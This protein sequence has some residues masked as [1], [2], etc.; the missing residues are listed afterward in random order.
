MHQ[1]KSFLFDLNGTMIDDMEYHIKAWYRILN[2][3][4]AGISME[5]TKEECYGKNHEL[6]DRVFPGRFS[7]E[8]KNKMS[9]EKERQY[10]EEF[11][12]HLQLLAGLPEVL[13]HYHSKGI[14]MAIGSAAIMYNIDFVLDGLGIRHYFQAIVSAD[15]VGNSKPDP[16]TYLKCAGLLHISPSDCL[17]FEDAPKGV[18]AAANA[19]MDCFVLTTMHHKNEFT[20]QNIIGFAKDFTN[21]NLLTHA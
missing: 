17:V 16:E 11:R 4:G 9:I 12:P 2:E 15:D 10:Q 1:Y 5:K 6:L 14:K 21:F 18:D 8:E 13:E 19:G 7:L 20:Q 3:L